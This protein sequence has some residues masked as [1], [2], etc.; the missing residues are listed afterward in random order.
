MSACLRRCSQ[1]PTTSGEGLESLPSL[2]V[3]IYRGVRSGSRALILLKSER[4]T[5]DLR[6]PV[7]LDEIRDFGWFLARSKSGVFSSPV[8]PRLSARCRTPIRALWQLSGYW[9]QRLSCPAPGR[10]SRLLSVDP[11]AFQIHARHEC[12]RLRVRGSGTG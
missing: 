11:T 9:R 3:L 6:S 4:K 5:S 7:C 12:R 10:G 2:S 8:R 1:F